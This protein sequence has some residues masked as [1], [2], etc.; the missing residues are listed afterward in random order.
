MLKEVSLQSKSIY[1]QGSKAASQDGKSGQPLTTVPS[2]DKHGIIAYPP[3]G[4]EY[5][6]RRHFSIPRSDENY[7]LF[8]YGTGSSKTENCIIYRIGRE[9]VY[10]SGE[11]HG[12]G[13]IYR[14]SDGGTVASFTFKYPHPNVQMLPEMKFSSDGRCWL[15]CF[16]QVSGND[17][18]LACHFYD[19]SL[20]KVTS[21]VTLPIL[22]T[23]IMASANSYNSVIIPKFSDLGRHVS[24][25]LWS[26]IYILACDDHGSW[27]NVPPLRIR[28]WPAPTGLDEPPDPSFVTSETRIHDTTGSA[29]LV[30]FGLENLKI[31]PIRTMIRAWDCRSGDQIKDMDVEVTNFRMTM[32]KVTVQSVPGKI[33]WLGS[34]KAIVWEIRLA[35]SRR[36]R[37]HL[38]DLTTKQLEPMKW[39]DL[40]RRDPLCMHYNESILKTSR[41]GRFLVAFG[42]VGLGQTHEPQFVSAMWD[43]EKRQLAHSIKDLVFTEGMWY[44][45][46]LKFCHGARDWSHNQDFGWEIWQLR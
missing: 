27:E 25:E 24:I 17:Q 40:P 43:L 26:S 36:D 33:A 32:S 39:I 9:H 28:K 20:W 45:D 44:S 30:A 8:K 16:L 2:T 23:D 22:D 7:Q 41:D 6:P 3:S 5:F 14:L 13:T 37:L 11:R 21:Q 38:L 34:S 42:C 15:A 46:D 19:T 18:V 4:A 1:E 35:T 31:S 10:S 29:T 12:T